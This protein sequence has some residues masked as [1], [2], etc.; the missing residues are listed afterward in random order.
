MLKCIVDRDAGSEIGTP[1]PT[2]AKIVKLS[3]PSDDLRG[4][5]F[6]IGVTHT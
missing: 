4:M 6:L 2:V 3:R 1:P 5:L